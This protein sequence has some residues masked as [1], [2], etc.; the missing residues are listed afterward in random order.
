MTY[1]LSLMTLDWWGRY[2]EHPDLA[3]IQKPW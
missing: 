3:T 1:L 2:G